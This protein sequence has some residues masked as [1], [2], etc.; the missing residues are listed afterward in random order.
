MCSIMKYSQKRVLLDM[1][2]ISSDEFKDFCRSS[3]KNHFTRNRKM[4][5]HELLLIMINSWNL[6]II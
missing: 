1:D 2:K 6:G 5:L 3:N 4:S